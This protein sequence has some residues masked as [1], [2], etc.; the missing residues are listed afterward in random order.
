LASHELAIGASGVGVLIRMYDALYDRRPDLDGRNYWIKRSEAGVS[1]ADIAER[2]VDADEATGGLDGQSFVAHLYRT[3]LEREATPLELA[4][5]SALLANGR[6]DRGDVLLAL[7]ESAEMAALVGV[8]STT[9]E[10]A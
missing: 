5:W 8:M 4:D 2:F 1:L 3:A 9:F 6:V 10:I 7:A